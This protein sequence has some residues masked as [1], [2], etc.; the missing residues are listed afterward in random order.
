MAPTKPNPLLTP[1]RREDDAD[2]S[3]RPLSLAE[4]VGQARRART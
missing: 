4:F 2:T 3:L 1:E